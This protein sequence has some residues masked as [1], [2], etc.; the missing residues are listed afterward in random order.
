MGA[1]FLCGFW[2]GLTLGINA[3]HTAVETVA[4]I[5]FI[6]QRS[7]EVPVSFYIFKGQETGFAEGTKQTD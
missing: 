6:P 1:L 2:H 7:M 5:T 3:T 4:S